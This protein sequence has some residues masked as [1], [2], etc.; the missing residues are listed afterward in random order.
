MRGEMREMR[1]ELQTEMREMRGEL[2]AD[3]RELR[4]GLS[5]EV[6]ELRS[7]LYDTRRWLTTMWLTGLL[8]LLAILVELSLR[9]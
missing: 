5:G 4:A 3:V 7:E 1:S 8:A 2:Q 9:T 6:N